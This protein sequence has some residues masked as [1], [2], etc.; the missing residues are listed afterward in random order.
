MEALVD[1]SREPAG[2]VLGIGD[3]GSPLGND[4]EL[5]S[6]PHCISVDSVCG[7]HKGSW[8]L[9]GSK[10]QGP[11]ALAR[12]LQSA[13]VRAGRATIDLTSLGLDLLEKSCT[14]QEQ[15]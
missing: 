2:L 6:G 5:L 12:I 11:A 14:K 1:Q 3:S 15:N 7:S 13:N 8:T 10:L 4:R 9:F